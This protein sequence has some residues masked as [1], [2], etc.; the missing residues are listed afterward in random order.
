MPK[1][2]YICLFTIVKQECGSANHGGIEK[3]MED[4]FD[5]VARDFT[6]Q[7]DGKDMVDFQGY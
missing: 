7:H 3:E 6:N 2:S 5:V 1:N 4:R